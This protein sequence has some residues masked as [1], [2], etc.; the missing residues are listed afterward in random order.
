MRRQT[1]G[2]QV[3]VWDMVPDTPKITV[4]FDAHSG[5]VMGCGISGDVVATGGKRW[6]YVCSAEIVRPLH[7]FPYFRVG[8]GALQGL[9]FWFVLLMSNTCVQRYR[10]L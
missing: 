10:V 5:E 8:F 3:H 7:T 9:C 1:P 6:L 4:T 2:G